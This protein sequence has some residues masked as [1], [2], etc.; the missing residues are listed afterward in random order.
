MIKRTTKVV[1]E[2]SLVVAVA[3]IKKTINPK[4]LMPIKKV[5]LVDF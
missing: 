3:M 1:E 5:A 2:T 4:M